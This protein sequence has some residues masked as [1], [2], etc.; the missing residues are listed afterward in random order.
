MNIDAIDLLS[1]PV[2]RLDEPTRPMVGLTFIQTPAD[3]QT[4]LYMVERSLVFCPSGVNAC[5]FKQ[6]EDNHGI[7]RC[8]LRPRK[9][10]CDKITIRKV[11]NV[12]S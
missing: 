5:H 3:G 10:I 11:E 4:N 12:P 2:L 1:L 6:D 7:S 9:W 8:L